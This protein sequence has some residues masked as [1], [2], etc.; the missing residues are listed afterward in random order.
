MPNSGCGLQSNPKK[1]GLPDQLHPSADLMLSLWAPLLWPKLIWARPGRPAPLTVPWARS[2]SAPWL[3]DSVK[4]SPSIWDWEP[5]KP[6]C[7]PCCLWRLWAEPRRMAR[8][9]PCREDWVECLPWPWHQ[10][11]WSNSL[12]AI[13][14]LRTS[15][16]SSTPSSS[17]VSNV[18]NINTYHLSGL[19][20]SH[21]A[22]SRSIQRYQAPSRGINHTQVIQGC[23]DIS[24]NCY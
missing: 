12:Q 8:L 9:G 6:C 2:K 3:W 7:W 13:H 22:P 23:T 5:W 1:S 14:E 10:L 11:R 19:I 21:R 16:A 15:R 4:D 17:Q 24:S 20:K 18:S